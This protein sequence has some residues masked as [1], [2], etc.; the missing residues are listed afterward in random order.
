[1]PLSLGVNFNLAPLVN[2]ILAFRDK[3]QDSWK[4]I[5]LAYRY[6]CAL[7]AAAGCDNHDMDFLILSL[8]VNTHTTKDFSITVITK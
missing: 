1:M 4:V 8:Q 3:L 2:R 7:R 5:T 6:I